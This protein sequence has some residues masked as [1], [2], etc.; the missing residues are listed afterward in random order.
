[1]EELNRFLDL[2]IEYKRDPTFILAEQAEHIRQLDTE[3]H[4]AECRRNYPPVDDTKY[5][6]VSPRYSPS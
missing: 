6:P 5:D 4:L 1:M 3:A 2:A